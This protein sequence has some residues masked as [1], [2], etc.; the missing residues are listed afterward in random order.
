MP[1]IEIPPIEEPEKPPPTIIVN[2]D[3]E[4]WNW[5]FD[6]KPWICPKC[7]QTNYGRNR[8]CANW[9]CR[10]PRPDEYKLLTKTGQPTTE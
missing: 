2:N 7:V 6:V 8:N 10:L 3:K 9:L 4:Y 1:R 5:V